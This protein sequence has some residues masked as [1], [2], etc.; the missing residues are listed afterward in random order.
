VLLAAL[1]SGCDFTGLAERFIPEAEAEFAKAHFE[2]LRLG[3]VDQVVAELNSQIVD[4]SVR[5]KIEAVVEYVP[6][7]EPL[8]FEVV[9]ANT[10]LANGTRT[11]TLNIQYEYPDQWL[12]FTISVDSSN[13]PFKVNSINA[14]LLEQSLAEINAFHLTQN[15]PIGILLVILGAAV[16]VFCI[17]VFVVCLRTPIPKGKWRWAIFTLLGVMTYQINWTTGQM[18]FTPMHIQLL[19]AGFARSGFYGPWVLGVS[20]PFGALVFLLKR[21]KWLES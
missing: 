19:G 10:H 6:D 15:G 12:V 1:L 5:E 20:I 4:D 16:P 2:L 11:V 21:K 14:N 13:E 7:D 17:V 3:D 8:G 18:G 9:G